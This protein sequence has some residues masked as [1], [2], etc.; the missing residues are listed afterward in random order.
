MASEERRGT[1]LASSVVLFI[2]EITSHVP[3]RFPAPSG[4]GWP[5]AFQP[6]F[7]PH[8]EEDRGQHGSSRGHQLS[9]EASP[10][11]RPWKGTA[12]G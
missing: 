6:P 8:A 2:L 7:S 9:P 11:G 1:G 3:T 4:G 10:L 5:S 12:A